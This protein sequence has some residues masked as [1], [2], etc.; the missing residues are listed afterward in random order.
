MATLRRKP[1][2]L[3]PEIG[4]VGIR[5]MANITRSGQASKPLERCV[6]IPAVLSTLSMVQR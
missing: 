1:A 2:F 3:Q 4:D 5:R 6:L